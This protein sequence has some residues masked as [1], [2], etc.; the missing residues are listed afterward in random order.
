MLDN[1]NCD[2]IQGG[3]ACALFFNKP[4]PRKKVKLIKSDLLFMFRCVFDGVTDLFLLF[5][6]PQ[7]VLILFTEHNTALFKL[8]LLLSQ[9]IQL[10]F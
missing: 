7:I 4:Y 6:C 9:F 1:N 10:L 2:F 3:E 5:Y 8:V